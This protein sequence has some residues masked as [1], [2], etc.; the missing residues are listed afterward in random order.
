LQKALKKNSDLRINILLDFLRGTR[1]S[2]IEKSSTSLLNPLLEEFPD[3]VKI[4]LYHTPHLYGIK[5]KII[6]ERINEV[7]GVQHIKSYIFDDNIIISG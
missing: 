6:P 2:N 3:Q 5:K 4:F 1:D 7:I